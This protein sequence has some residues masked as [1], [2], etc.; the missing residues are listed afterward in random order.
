[1]ANPIPS[2]KLLN[3]GITPTGI[4]NKG[5]LIQKYT[6]PVRVYEYNTDGDIKDASGTANPTS[7][8]NA[9]AGFAK[10][11]VYVDT[12]VATGTKAMYENVGTSSSS[13]WNLLGETAAGDITLADGKVLIGGATGVAAAQSL[14][15]DV[16]ITNTGVATVTKATGAFNVGTSQTFTKEL[17]HT[18]A[19]TTTTTAATVGGALS[20][21]AGQGATSG[22]GGVAAVAAG[23][24]GAT[25]AGGNATL[26]SGAG[27]ATSGVS[28]DVY[29]VSGSTAAGSGSA[30][31][32]VSVGSGEGATSAVAVA[33][34][35]SGA[36]SLGS[37]GGGANTGGAT[38]QVGGA[39]GAT[40]LGSGDGG[41]TNSQGAHAGGA[42]GAVNIRGGAGGNATAGTGN[43]GAGAS[44]INTAGQ[45]GTSAGGTAGVGGIIFDRSTRSQKYSVTAMTTTAAITTT[46]ILG[47]MIT[48][49]QGAAG[50][51]T[52]TLPTGVELAAALPAGFTTGDSVDFTIVNIS[53]NA[54]EDVTVAGA[55]GTTAIGNLFVPSND[56]TSS[57]SF[58]TF[59]AINTGA[60]TFN[61]YR[62]A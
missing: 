22:A 34:G 1:M 56:A 54:A 47:G 14:S 39:S 26:Y 12:D 43:G 55:G 24:G 52:Y 37:Q 7:S 48:A 4:V 44:I 8:L 59:R 57:I 18:V 20:L 5:Y 30:T 51:A 3:R 25:G 49:N 45:G 58:G 36:V 50:A 23:A 38:G 19:V 33:G 41:A 29:V 28:G 6:V 17:N 11:A 40:D 9:V 31:G 13:S 27:G 61:V 16:T 2:S 35:A 46:A 42:G 21:S 62:V 53:T 15:Q 60:G 10:S 32:Q